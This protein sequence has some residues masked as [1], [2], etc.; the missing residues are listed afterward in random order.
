MQQYYE[1]ILGEKNRI[2]YQTKFDK[3]DKNGGGIITSWNWAALFFTGTWALY[4]KM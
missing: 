4:R 3:F 2:Y 1:A